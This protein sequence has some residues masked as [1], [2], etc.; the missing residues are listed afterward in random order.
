MIENVTIVDK[1]GNGILA[2]GL[3]YIN[4]KSTGTKYV[5]Y[6]LNEMVDQDQTKIYIAET[7][8]AVGQ[9]SPIE[10][11]EWKYLKKTMVSIA[12]NEE[13]PDIEHIKMTGVTFNISDPKKLAV[14]LPVKQ[15]LKDTQFQKTLPGQA[16]PV[17]TASSGSYFDQSVVA[18]QEPVA[19]VPVEN[20]INIFNNPPQ[21]VITETMPVE[22]PIVQEMVAPIAPPVVQTQLI[23]T[24]EETIPEVITT[25]TNP[26]SGIIAPMPTPEKLVEEP[27]I[28]TPV[29]PVEKNVLA[30]EPSLTM[31]T[32]E[33]VEVAEEKVTQKENEVT[34]EQAVEAMVTLIKYFG[35]SKEMTDQVTQAIVNNVEKTEEVVED[36]AQVIEEKK[37]E[38]QSDLMSSIITPVMQETNLVSDMATP[39]VESSPILNVIQ[40]AVEAP[41]QEAS[42]ETV[43]E[44]PVVESAPTVESNVE[45]ELVAPVVPEVVAM[46]EI[47]APAVETIPTASAEPTESEFQNPMSYEAST[48]SPI[49]N[50]IDTSVQ[51]IQNAAPAPV[52]EEP[53][54]PGLTPV[55]FAVP[56]TN[57]SGT[58]QPVTPPPTM[59]AN[60][61]PDV[62]PVAE[63]PVEYT[64]TAQNNTGQV[65]INNQDPQQVEG[66]GV[67][68]PDNAKNVQ[69]ITQGM[70]GQEMLG[71]SGL[72]ADPKTLNLA[73]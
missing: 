57:N 68:M 42:V 35:M 40:N 65:I 31:P 67:V 24:K 45:V 50:I 49:A 55:E 3:M 44:A 39:L 29:M 46:P 56:E 22:N 15:A 63:A 26:S 13:L 12:H 9:A 52:F 25:P 60:Y 10:E 58:L 38:P 48:V 19:E 18:V 61:I 54:N 27:A 16:E 21:P 2:E 33:V 34:R 5:F 51:G 64:H 69:V 7:A 41:A 47:V 70:H 62:T 1:N 6:T 4:V 17:V 59:D 37:V 71:P 53:L 32:N 8:D 20:G 11:E 28:G 36:K 23:E 66:P 14:K 30:E 73:S 72:V 43:A